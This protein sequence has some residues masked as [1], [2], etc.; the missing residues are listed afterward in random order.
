M[1]LNEIAEDRMLIKSPMGF[2]RT[3]LGI[4]GKSVHSGRGFFEMNFDC[5][6]EELGEKIERMIVGNA[7]KFIVT[8]T[9]TTVRIELK[10]ELSFDEYYRTLVFSPA[11]FMKLTVHL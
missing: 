6:V 9:E 1:K 5:S 7:D 3:K 11:A 2:F 4:K 10:A 8:R